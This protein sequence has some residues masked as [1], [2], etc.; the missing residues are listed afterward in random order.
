MGPTVVTAQGTLLGS[1]E[2]CLVFRGIPY[3]A[4]PLGDRRFRAPASHP[5]W[6]GVR[7]ARTFG[8]SAIQAAAEPPFGDLFSTT[9]PDEDCLTLNVWTPALAPDRRAVLVWFHGGGLADGSSAD[10]LYAGDTFARDGVVFVSV[11]YRLGALGFLYL[12]ELFDGYAESGNVGVL[13]QVAALRWVRENIAAFGGDPERVTICGES[14]GGW[15]VAT[16]MATPAAR[17]LFEGAIC[18]SGAGDHAL[19]PERATH[20]ARRVL[21]AAGIAPGDRDALLALTPQQLVAAQDIAYGAGMG[22][23]GDADALLGDDAGLIIC[24]LPVIDGIVLPDLPERAVAGGSA[25]GVRL[26]IGSN[27]DEYGLYRLLDGG[28]FTLEQLRWYSDRALLAAGADPAAAWATYAANRPG[29][30]PVRIAE[31]ME[32]DR[33]FRLPALSFAH[34]QADWGEV[35]VYRLDWSGTDYGAC[36]VMDVPLVF[37]RADH[38]ATRVLVGDKPPHELARALHDAWVAFA[39]DGRPQSELLPPWPRWNR[40]RPTMLIDAPAS[41]VSYDPAGNERRVWDRAAATRP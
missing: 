9:E 8:A 11:N 39:R 16:L 40:M 14:A 28:I 23:Q 22:S 34:A 24:L 20:V 38:P 36:H 7:D 6:E 10:P 27:A 41:C 1:D 5:E 30:E 17:G 2:G 33:F 4:P 31:A 37:D 21:E 19:R 35:W 12:A 25:A 3:A 26:M 18:S 32:T 13:D 15:S 29:A